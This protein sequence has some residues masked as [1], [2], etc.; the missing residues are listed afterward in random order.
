MQ[1][2]KSI[3]YTYDAFFGLYV[4]GTTVLFLFALIRIRRII[5]R[6]KLKI[7]LKAQILNLTLVAT[8][9]LMTLLGLIAFV[10]AASKDETY[11]T[12]EVEARFASLTLFIF[13]QVMVC[14]VVYNVYRPKQPLTTVKYEAI[15]P[16]ELSDLSIIYSDGYQPHHSAS[17]DLQSSS[18][19]QTVVT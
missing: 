4:F 14:I 1:R 7:N 9:F 5:Q 11:T 3:F 2:I 6:Y 19:T 13:I 10:N 15:S 16:D 18:D 12:Y 8:Y 17:D